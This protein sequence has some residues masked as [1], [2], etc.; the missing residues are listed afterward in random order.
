MLNSPANMLSHS[1][2]CLNK[3]N[4]CDINKTTVGDSKSTQQ[5]DLIFKQKKWQLH[6]WLTPHVIIQHELALPLWENFSFHMR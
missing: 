2:S 6:G 1:R 4:Y 5:P 3:M